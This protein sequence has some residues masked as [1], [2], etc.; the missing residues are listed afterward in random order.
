MDRNFEK[1]L[2]AVLK[3]EGGYSNHPADNGGPT[4]KGVTL[5]NFRRYVKI[6]GTIDDLKKLTTAQ[7]GIIY[8]RFYWDKVRADELPDGVDYAVFDF[9]VNS[10]PGRAIKFLQRA[11]GVT[12]D[13]EIGPKTIAAA[14]KKSKA[15]VI[16]AICSTRLAWLKGLHD[17]PVFKNGWT[18]R[19]NGV[20]SLAVALALQ[21]HVPS[22]TPRPM[23]KPSPRPELP[24]YHPA[25]APDFNWTPIIVT[26]LVLVAVA[27]LVYTVFI[28]R[29]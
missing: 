21:D 1:A 19:I 5:E 22:E 8:R 15:D 28:K 11:V 7:A 26:V 10:G 12:Q 16:E 3:H 23:P 29:G 4:N 6:N 13:G 17:W 9:A 25:Q 2:A 18:Y 27:W 20:R 24:K 14:A